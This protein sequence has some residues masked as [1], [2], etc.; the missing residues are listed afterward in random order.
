MVDQ[1]NNHGFDRPTVGADEDAW[2]GHLN[3]T[4]DDLEE[5]VIVRDTEANRTNYTAYVDALFIATDTGTFFRGDGSS[6]NRLSVGTATTTIDD[7]D[8]P[9]LTADEDVIYADT[10]AGAVTITLASADATLANQIRIVNLDGTNDV[11]LETESSET[12]GDG[13]ASKSISTAGWSVGVTW[14]GGAWQ[15]S[16]DGEFESV[17]TNSLSDGVDWD[18]IASGSTTQLFGFVDDTDSDKQHFELAAFTDGVSTTA[19]TIFSRQDGENVGL[20][21]VAG[22]VSGGGPQFFDLV[23]V[24]FFNTVSTVQSVDVSGPATRT[25][26]VSGEDLMLEMGGDTYDVAASGTTL[27]NQ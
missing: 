18:S 19:A 14:S 3:D 7:T 2:G 5:T 9:Y 10:S 8:S 17:S 12:F 23:M 6:W 22:R 16:L 13:S 24:V 1:T 21:S 11:T 27:R 20:V 15:T 4:I 26:S 25:Y